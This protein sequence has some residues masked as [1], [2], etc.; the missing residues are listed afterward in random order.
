MM[1]VNLRYTNYNLFLSE[2]RA[3][4]S[5]F[6]MNDLNFPW[7]VP[8]MST[9]WRWRTY[10]NHVI[11]DNYQEDPPFRRGD[12]TSFFPLHLLLFEGHPRWLPQKIRVGL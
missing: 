7:K 3:H 1:L 11:P 12:S 5:W 2:V 10:S 6:T 4:N 8:N 9:N